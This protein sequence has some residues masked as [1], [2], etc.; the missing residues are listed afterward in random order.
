MIDPSV[1]LRGVTI[2]AEDTR[3]SLSPLTAVVVFL[4]SK[5]WRR[6][7]RGPQRLKKMTMII[8]QAVSK[9]PMSNPVTI[10]HA[11]QLESRISG[12]PVSAD[13]VSLV[14]VKLFAIV[15]RGDTVSS[16]SDIDA[17]VFGEKRRGLL[18][19][20]EIMGKPW[21]PR[22]D[23]I[24]L[25]RMWSEQWSTMLASLY[26]CRQPTGP[27]VRS[28]VVKATLDHNGVTKLTALQPLEVVCK[29]KE[30]DRSLRK[31][32]KRN[33]LIY[34]PTDITTARR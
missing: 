30:R 17:G 28:V 32:G 6:A 7:G 5:S 33:L 11:I 16:G 20:R 29:P 21:S 15:G 31:S 18:R 25:H 12:E 4:A 14:N 23:F 34:N 8:A 24:L 13:A 1:A 2:V 19:K 22:D 9:I 27:V 10:V 3:H 26:G